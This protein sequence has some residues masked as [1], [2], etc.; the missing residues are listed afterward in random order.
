MNILLRARAG[1]C[2]AAISEGW[3]IRVVMTYAGRTLFD[4][5]L[6][7]AATVALARDQCS[8]N[9]PQPTVCPNFPTATVAQTLH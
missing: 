1:I 5:A 6:A 4:S 2:R 9:L 8:G 7:T 3:L